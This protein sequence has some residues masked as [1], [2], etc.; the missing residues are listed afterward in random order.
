MAAPRPGKPVR[1]STTGRPVMALLDLLSRRWMLR[2]IWEIRD[3]PIGFRSLQRGCEQMSPSV[4]SQR[5]TE[6]VEARILMQSESKEYEF[7]VEGR[8]LFDL[9]NPL[10]EWSERWAKQL[11]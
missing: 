6:L 11:E 1:G 2:V 9:M 10:H 5:L 8:E 7:T 4:L 3:G